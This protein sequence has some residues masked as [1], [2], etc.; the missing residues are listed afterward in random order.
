MP[1]FYLKYNFKPR[2]RLKNN[3]YTQIYFTFDLI[4]PVIDDLAT[5]AIRK[6]W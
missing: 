5:Q 4:I 2:L 6:T 1:F 3:F